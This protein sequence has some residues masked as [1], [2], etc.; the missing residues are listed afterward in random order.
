MDEN[1]D[2]GKPVDSIYRWV[3]F[4]VETLYHL[5]GPPLDASLIHQI[6]TLSSSLTHPGGQLPTTQK[7][8]TIRVLPGAGCICWGV[9]RC[10][11]CW[12]REQG[13]Q[14]GIL[15]GQEYVNTCKHH[16]N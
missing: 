14:G 4:V 6:W 16:H 3:E 13:M 12:I 10:H 5:E 1:S 7:T 15:V 11:T 2:E 9:F 8:V